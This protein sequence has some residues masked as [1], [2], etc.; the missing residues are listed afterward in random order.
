MIVLDTNIISELWRPKP[1]Q[2]VLRWVQSQRS[3]FLF[4]CAPVLAELRYGAE[5]LPAGGRKDRI[6]AAI[7][8]I[9]TEVYRD[10]ILPFDVA[11]AAEFGRLAVRRERLG[12]RMQS[13]DATIASI[14]VVHGASLATRDVYDFADLGFEVINPFELGADSQT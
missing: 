8:R 7:D 4:L 5:R 1:D 9:E 2:A 10:R 3:G 6:K 11:A 14:V 12:R 13:M